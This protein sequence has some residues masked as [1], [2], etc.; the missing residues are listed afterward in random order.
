[1]QT[2][3]TLH[4]RNRVSMRSVS[5]TPV[6][7][8]HTCVNR[9]FSIMSSYADWIPV[10]STSTDYEA[11]M[12]RDR[13]DASGIPAVVLTKRDHAFNLNVGDLADVNVFVPPTREEEARAVLNEKLSDEELEEAAMNADPGVLDAEPSTPESSDSEAPDSSDAS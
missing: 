13:L 10:F 1:M 3:L 5:F 7:C 9:F 4:A 12:A 11:D 2:A 8:T 6:C